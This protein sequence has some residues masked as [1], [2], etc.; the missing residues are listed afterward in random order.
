MEPLIYNNN[1]DISLI[2]TPEEYVRAVHH[3]S[4]EVFI[5]EEKGGFVLNDIDRINGHNTYCCPMDTAEEA[6]ILQ[7]ERCKS[8]DITGSDNAR[9]EDADSIKAFIAEIEDDP[10]YAEELKWQYHLL[11]MLEISPE[12]SSPQKIEV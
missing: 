6:W 7:M 3:D 4:Q 1:G 5:S 10:D 2:R 8:F 11:K 9:F 12:F